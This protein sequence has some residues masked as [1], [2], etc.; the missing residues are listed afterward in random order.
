MTPL[1]LC[2][3]LFQYICRVNR[4]ARKNIV[5][6]M[7]QVRSEVRQVLEDIRGRASADRRLAAQFDPAGGRLLLVLTFF[8]DF[9]VR[10]GSLSFANEWEDLAAEQGETNGDQRFWEFLEETLGDRSED[11]VQR[12]AV[13]YTCIGL[14]FTGWYAGQPEYLRRK[15]L[16]LSA[17]LRGHVP[18]DSAGNICPEA[19]ENVNTDNLIVPPSRSLAGIGIALVGMAVVLFAANA[20]L[21]FRSRSN[22]TDSVNQVRAQPAPVVQAGQP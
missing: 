11:A 2:E 6:D 20:F 15:M 18:I 8:A 16:E 19:Y 21:Y 13:F 5:Y 7:E 22:L 10:S 17:R 14:G 1:D 9:M 3:P 4:S 12:L